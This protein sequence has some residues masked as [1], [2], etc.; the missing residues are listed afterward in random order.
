MKKEKQVKS[1]QRRTKSGKVVTV[2]AH[3]AT[4]DAAEKAAEMA[5][6]K[7]AG[8]ELAA[9]KKVQNVGDEFAATKDVSAKDFK[10]WYLFNDWDTPKNSWPQSV[11]IADSQIRQNL[12]SKK[13]YDEY[14]AKID[15]DWRET[16]Y[17]AHHQT[18]RVR[19]RPELPLRTFSDS[20]STEKKVP[21]SEKE[22]PE[23]K[24]YS[25]KEIRSAAKYVMK[26]SQPSMKSKADPEKL[27]RA[28]QIV[29]QE[30][31]KDKNGKRNLSSYI[32]SGSSD[33]STDN[34]PGT[35]KKVRPVGSGTNGPTPKRKSEA[36][37]KPT[38]KKF[39][40]D[41][42]LRKDRGR[43]S[44]SGM[45]DTGNG[46]ISVTVHPD[47][48]G[49]GYAVSYHGK[50]GDTIQ[51]DTF[52][53]PSLRNLSAHIKDMVSNQPYIRRSHRLVGSKDHNSLEKERKSANWFA[54]IDE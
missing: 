13:K 34:K 9:K 31:P 41:M 28:Q 3:T 48:R 19:P 18:Y 35:K 14:C 10:E 15:S 5:K 23:K 17:I 22:T 8:E 45:V 54:D 1:Y 36:V 39:D 53:L 47:K 49:R 6:K 20:T 38:T 44:Y 33:I 50:Y 2:K 40:S 51:N 7:G 42:P 24:S 27:R 21:K 52:N 43:S 25:M 32:N 30:I 4:Y 46:K 29:E 16:G 11:R 37:G 26:Y 12:G